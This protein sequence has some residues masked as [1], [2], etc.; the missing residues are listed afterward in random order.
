MTQT[1]RSSAVGEGSRQSYDE[2]LVVFFQLAQTAV[3]RIIR[4]VLT[5]RPLINGGSC[6]VDVLLIKRRD[7]TI[8]SVPVGGRPDCQ[9]STHINYRKNR[10]N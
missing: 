8:T 3:S 5:K 10:V 6:G 9:I 2:G 1:M 4:H 7:T